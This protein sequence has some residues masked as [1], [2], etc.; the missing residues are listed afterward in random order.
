[1]KPNQE[2]GFDTF[3][4]YFG[5]YDS[6]G[7]PSSALYANNLTSLSTP[8]YVPISGYGEMASDPTTQ[9]FDSENIILVRY[10]ITPPV[11]VSY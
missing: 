3:E 7:V 10:P 9:L 5:P 4:E 2:E 6:L 11:L 1:M 8:A